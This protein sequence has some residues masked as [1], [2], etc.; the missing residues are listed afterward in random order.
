[1]GIASLITELSG[2]ST[3]VIDYA[4]YISKAN[5]F[6]GSN[7]VDHISE[8]DLNSLQGQILLAYMKTSY[9]GKI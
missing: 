6:S 1:M 4:H 2:T 8:D 5:L 7:Y 9:V 3:C